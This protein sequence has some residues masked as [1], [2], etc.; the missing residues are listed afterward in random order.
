MVSAIEYASLN[1]ATN[2]GHAPAAPSY[3]YNAF[4]QALYEVPSNQDSKIMSALN[5]EM[6]QMRLTCDPNIHVHLTR[7]VGWH[8]AYLPLPSETNAQA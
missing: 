8:Q 2:L 3:I 6:V 1:R 7:R 4:L 5:F